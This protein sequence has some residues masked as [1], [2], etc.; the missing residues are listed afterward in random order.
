M[1]KKRRESTRKWQNGKESGAITENEENKMNHCKR[2]R[3]MREGL[4][5]FQQKECGGGE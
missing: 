5:Q 3:E 4:M 1:G 2:V